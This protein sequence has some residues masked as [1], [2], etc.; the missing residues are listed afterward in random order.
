MPMPMSTAL[1][2]RQD[3]LVQPLHRSTAITTSGPDG[4]SLREPLPERLNSGVTGGRD[5]DHLAG[6]VGAHPPEPS[7]VVLVVVDHEGAPRIGTHVRQAL[8]AARALR[9]RVDGRVDGVVDE[10]EHDRDDVRSAVR[11]HRREVGDRAGREPPTQFG[12][13]HAPSPTAGRQAGA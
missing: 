3:V 4:R 7:P 1:S 12:G 2:S 6:P 13:L 10:G 9:L 11:P 5:V 8:Q